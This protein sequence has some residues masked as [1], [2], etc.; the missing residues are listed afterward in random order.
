MPSVTTG[1]LFGQNKGQKLRQG[2]ETTLEDLSKMQLAPET[3]AA[4]EQAMAA[5][6]Q[7]LDPYTRQQMLQGLAMSSQGALGL[8]RQGRLGLAKAADI[9]R[10]MRAGLM[11]FGAAE[12]QARR[13]NLGLATQV[14]LGVGQQRLGLEQYKNQGLYNY[15]T[16]RLRERRETLSN[17]ITGIAQVGG[18]IAASA[19]G[20]PT[21]LTSGVTSGKS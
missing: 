10:S 20:A 13:Q 9:D 17:I 2:V 21:Y 11:Q 16:G 1:T 5:S 12:A 18:Q 19:A 15:L 7:G 6:K 4:Y 14:G 8:Y 3:T